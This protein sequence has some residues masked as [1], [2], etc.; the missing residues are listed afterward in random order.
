MPSKECI[1]RMQVENFQ[2]DKPVRSS[3]NAA[4]NHPPFID[5]LSGKWREPP[6][7]CLPGST[8]QSVAYT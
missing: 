3:K 8:K 6:G 7:K 4:T 2:D 1:A 5:P